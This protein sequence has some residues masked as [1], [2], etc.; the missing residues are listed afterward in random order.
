MKKKK[1]LKD[2]LNLY[3]EKFNAHVTLKISWVPCVKPVVGLSDVGCIII[4]WVT[5]NC[6]LE[7]IF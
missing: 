3:P 2:W 5:I 1:L 7:G 4:N 6:S